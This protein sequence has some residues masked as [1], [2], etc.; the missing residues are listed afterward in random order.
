MQGWLVPNTA[1]QRERRTASV[2][3]FLQFMG[4]SGGLLLSL[5]L[6]P[7]YFTDWKAFLFEDTSLLTLINIY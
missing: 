5:V 7:V 3:E 2:R 1:H 6:S 4:Q